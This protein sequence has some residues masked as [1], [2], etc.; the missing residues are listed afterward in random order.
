MFKVFSR[1]AFA[2]ATMITIAGTAAAQQLPA[3]STLNGK[4]EFDAGALSLPSPSFAGRAAGA[5][6]VPVGERF[7]VQADFSAASASGTTFGAALHVFARDPASHLIGGTLGVMRTPGATVLAAGPE[8]E[9]YYGRWTIE[10]WGGV[11][12]ARPAVGPDRVG[13][14]GMADVAFYPHDN[15]RLSLGLSTL[16]GYG[17]VHAGAEYM[18]DSFDMPLSLTA[19][20]RLGQD[21]ALL[22]TIGLRGYFGAAPKPLIDRHRQDDPTDR[23]SALY[24]A[25]GGITLRAAPAATP[26][27]APPAGEDDPV[28]DPE[29]EDDPAPEPDPQPEENPSAEQPPPIVCLKF[30]YWPIEGKDYCENSEGE[31]DR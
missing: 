19:D 8:A 6:T 18:F 14:F 21:G 24:A 17:A 11:S 5:I 3:V 10:A 22:A 23:G 2:A 20:A 27:T 9:L 7:G 26:T 1:A 25:A 31:R 29:P 30:E 16:D 15:L 28:V 4:F 13:L 12:F